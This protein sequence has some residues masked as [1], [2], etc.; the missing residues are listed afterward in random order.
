MGGLYIR[1]KWLIVPLFIGDVSGI[2]RTLRDCNVPEYSNLHRQGFPFSTL[3]RSLRL[4]LSVLL[5]YS[6]IWFQLR[7]LL[8][9]IPSTTQP[10]EALK[11]NR[12][13]TV[14][15]SRDH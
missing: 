6:L 4:R 7:P 15:S 14:S 8:A 10:S 5:G 3:I 11:W 2:A 9:W 13:K 1:I 12:F